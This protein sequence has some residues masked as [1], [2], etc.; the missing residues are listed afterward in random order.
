M[1]YTLFVFN[2]LSRVEELDTFLCSNISKCRYIFV[3]LGPAQEFSAFLPLHNFFRWL[4]DF[5]LLKNMI[6]RWHVFS[7]DDE[8]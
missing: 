5:F 2:F 3:L 4:L 1:R 8:F 7:D 6:L